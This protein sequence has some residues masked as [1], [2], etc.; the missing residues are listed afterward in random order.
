[1]ISDNDI[2]ENV[3]NRTEAKLL[4]TYCFFFNI[5]ALMHHILYNNIKQWKVESNDTTMKIMHYK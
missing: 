2:S 5:K 1:M 3:F 4:F